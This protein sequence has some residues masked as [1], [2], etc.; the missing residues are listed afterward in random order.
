MQTF[1][2]LYDRY[3]LNMIKIS[4]FFTRT[5]TKIDSSLVLLELNKNPMF[6]WAFI[7]KYF[8]T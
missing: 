1:E 8:Y 6:V 5:K 2:I 7:L 3:S 4:F